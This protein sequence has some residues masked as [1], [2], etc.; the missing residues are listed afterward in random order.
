M[1]KQFFLTVA[2]LASGLAMAEQPATQPVPNQPELPQQLQSGEPLEPEV[3]IIQRGTDTVYE[4]RSNGQLY[5]V[6]VIPFMGPPYFF[7][8]SNGDGE[9]D[10]RQYGDPRHLNVNQWMLFSW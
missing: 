4:Y 10:V 6:R 5:M 1:K 9:L 7:L 3:T 8:D 2:L